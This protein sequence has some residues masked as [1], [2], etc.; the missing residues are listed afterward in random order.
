M[1]ILCNGFGEIC[2]KGEDWE[3]CIWCHGLCENGAMS[4]PIHHN[5]TGSDSQCSSSC[6]N[7]WDCIA[8]EKCSLDRD[9]R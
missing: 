8:F 7:D 6:G 3:D 5:Y 2:M 4:E 1:N 9:L